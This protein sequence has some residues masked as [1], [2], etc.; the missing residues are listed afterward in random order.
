MADEY[1]FRKEIDELRLL[2]NQLDLDKSDKGGIATEEYVLSMINT[3]ISQDVMMRIGLNQPSS[4]KFNFATIKKT[5]TALDQSIITDEEYWILSNAYFDY[6][7]NRFIKIDPEH[8]SFGIQIQANGSYPGE[9]QLGYAD[10]VGIN[11]W[12]NPKKSDVEASFPNWRNDPVNDFYPF[13]VDNEI[14]LGL[15]S[16]S[17]YWR[18]F[19]VYAGWSNSFMIDSYGGMTIGGAGFEMDGNGIFPFT[20]LSSSRYYDSAEDKVWYL[21]GLLDNAYHPTIGGWSCDDNSTWSWFF[22]L[23]T[24]EKSNLVKDNEETKFVI[25]YNDTPYN[26]SNK[27]ELIIADWNTILEVSP[28]EIKGMVNGT[29]STLGTG[30]GSGGNVPDSG[31]IALTK[32]S[33]FW[34]YDAT[35]KVRYR[36]YGNI[37][38][39]QG[40][41]Q[42]SETQ[43][44]TS[45]LVIGQLPGGYR[46]TNNQMFL[47]EMYNNGDIWTCKVN[48]YGELSLSRV[49]NHNGAVIPTNNHILNINLT[50]IV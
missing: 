35:Y 37:V 12:R 33:I 50:F 11:F 16:D 8:T 44:D 36:K 5:E 25:M 6:E 40:L 15:H 28:S 47:Q 7:L 13:M 30:G 39:V 14:G 45:D 18:E 34:N 1:Q 4:S 26:A 49:R 19:G 22:G 9:A 21:L 46:P 29:L 23:K 48:T 31:W 42:L 38:Q 10:N 32:N 27:E 24:P 3:A 43:T 20:R 41:T 2:L 17:S